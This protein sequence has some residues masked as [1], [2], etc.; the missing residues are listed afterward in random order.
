M[1]ATSKAP[2]NCR[3]M[4]QTLGTEV[5]RNNLNQNIWCILMDMYIRS[6]PMV[7][8]VIITDLRFKNEYEYVSRIGVTVRVKGSFKVKHPILTTLTNFDM[9]FYEDEQ[10]DCDALSQ[11]EQIDSGS[12][13]SCESEKLS[14]SYDSLVR[15]ISSAETLEMTGVFNS[16]GSKTS[17][18]SASVVDGGVS[19]TSSKGRRSSTSSS[20][21]IVQSE[22]KHISETDLEDEE[23]DTEI[24]NRGSLFDLRM[25]IF[26]FN[27]IHMLFSG[28]TI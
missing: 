22:M 7:T 14:A 16:V 8:I 10:F 27:W 17:V 15:K 24:D 12:D 26:G 1:V 25:K 28:V 9:K 19:Y 4:L 5:F 11:S 21:P 23:F 2:M 20:K 6:I 18:K 3:K 13:V